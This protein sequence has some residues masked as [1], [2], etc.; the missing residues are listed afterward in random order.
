VVGDIAYG[1]PLR[2]AEVKAAGDGAWEVSGYASVFGV[3]DLGN[4]VVHKGAFADTLASGNRV[5]FLYSHNPEHVLGAPLALREDEKGL[6]GRWRI[7]KTP[8]GESVHTLLKDSALDSFSIGYVP[9]RFDFDEDTGTRHLREVELVEVSVVAM[10]MLPQAL[11]T[12]VKA[13]DYSQL[14]L[15]AIVSTFTEHRAS[16]LAAA[17]ALA[18]RRRSEGRKLSDRVV[19]LLEALRAASLDD[20]DTLLALLTAPPPER[21]EK[22]Q[23]E[24]QKADAPPAQPT[25]EAKAD[26]PGAPDPTPDPVAVRTADS[27]VEAHLRRARL[28]ALRRKY[29]DVRLPEVD[30]VA[31]LERLPERAW[32]GDAAS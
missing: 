19:E 21:A 31:A 28:N 12:G 5:R 30:P 20:A 3:T 1:A 14:S 4:D 9:K 26:A 7:S 17:K 15:D 10:P 25:A 11:V 2:V 8:L 22:A 6:F 29:A 18:E 24:P 16:A 27:L 23:P 32:L 13:A